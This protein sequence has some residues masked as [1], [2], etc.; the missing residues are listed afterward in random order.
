MW[1]MM[2]WGGGRLSFKFKIIFNMKQ[3]FLLLLLAASLHGFTQQKFQHQ[4]TAANTSN[5]STWLNAEGVN[6]NPNAVII[7]EYD[8]ATRAANPH[9]VGVWYDGNKWAVFNQDLAPMPAGI[10]FNLTWKNA[11][12]SAFFIK[13]SSANLINGKMAIDAAALNNNPS[14]GFY[15]S[16]VWNP[17]GVGGVYNNADISVVF[18]KSLLK[19]LV[20]NANGSALPEGAAFSI[21]ITGAKQQVATA[22]NVTANPV[23]TNINPSVIISA[24]TNANLDFELGNTKWTATGT[25][26]NNQPVR[27]NTVTTNRVLT[28]MMYAN[29]GVGGDY[30]QGLPYPI[31]IKGEQW[32]GTYENGNGDAPTGSFTSS[33]MRA[34]QRYFSFLLGGGKDFNKLY[35]ELQVKK[36]DYET[37]WGAGKK[38][39]FGETEDGFVRV[40]R[41][42]SS[43]NSEELFRYYFDLD[44]ELNHQFAGKTIRIRIVDDKTT[45]WGHINVDDMMQEDNLNNYLSIQ[46]DGFGLLADN[47]KPVWGY[48]DSHAHPAADEAFGKKYYVGSSRTP[49]STTWGNDVCTASHT[50]GATLD[51]FTNTFDPHKF[52]DGGWPNM[53]GFPKFNGKMHQK[54]QVDL[55]KRAW[56]GGLKIFCALGINNM[57]L[58]TR[59][60]GHGT[61]GEAADDESVLLRQVKVMKDM[62]R[63]NKEWMEIA[64]TPADARRIIVEGKLCVILGLESDVFGNFKSPGCGWADRGEDRPLV[65][66][67]EADANEKLEQKLNEYHALGLR[68]ILPLHYLSKPFGGTAVFN[69]NTFLPQI[70]FYDHVNIKTGVP[71]RI[72]FSLYE[73]F[74]I[75]A[76]LVGNGI[77]FAA[78]AARAHKQDEGTEISMVNAEGLSPI[79]TI[80]F[81][82]LMKKGFIIDQEHASYESKRDMFRLSAANGNYPIMASHAGPQGLSFLWTGAP[83]RFAG[84]NEQKIQNF[85]TSTIRFVAH[86]MELNDESYS[87]I[88]NTSGTVGVFALLNHKKQYTGRWGNIANDCPGSSKTVAQ[89][90]CY[91]LDRMNGKGVGLASDL[92]MVDGVCPRFGPYAAF[93]LTNEEAGVL[94]EGQ[95]TASRMA[96]T[97]GVKYDV[98]SKSYHPEFFQGGQVDGFEED[99]WKALAAWEAGV[100]AVTNEN[101]VAES[102]APGHAGRIRNV[103]KGFNRASANE[104][105]RPCLTCGAAPWEQAAAFC[106]KNNQLPN[107]LGGFDGGAIN[108]ISKMYNKMLPV[109]NIW[110]AKNGSNEALRRCITGNRYWDFNLDGLAHYGLMPDLLQDLKNIGFTKLQLQPLFGSAE[111]YIQMWEKAEA[112]KVN[113]R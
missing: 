56:Q 6:G 105:L 8:A 87:G 7:V 113:V 15:A 63:E 24:G 52:F 70:T 30:W 2:P 84:T 95:R 22:G 51:G 61:N 69:G 18:D 11:E 96:Q 26:F 79:G 5:N 106:L 65:T 49:L 4:S 102:G 16:Q 12:A 28:K 72:G 90:F 77:T 54:Y 27:G 74:P 73:D 98:V 17:G 59:A 20:Q 25:A 108:E 40:N 107:T 47:D 55:I 41:I 39:L 57:Y 14:A 67:T 111:D 92:P 100:N 13:A 31:G 10:N 81:T 99:M 66:I 32:I 89:M 64:Y 42:T 80:L 60:L 34:G 75:G 82:K 97:N 88:K 33:A 101:A 68:Q 78:Y 112:E 71:D 91:S 36:T 1:R 85:N 9:P 58:A 48:F 50:W 3:L 93:A 53:W 110:K 109:W 29:G 23:L 46:K 104:L 83:V 76:G 86:E 21:I 103:V 45:A 94:K 37:A 44:A 38:S 62:A 43:L 35:V 19:W